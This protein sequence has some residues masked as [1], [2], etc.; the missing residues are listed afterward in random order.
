MAKKKSD[1]MQYLLILV[2]GIAIAG[3]LFYMIPYRYK[4][5][6]TETYACDHSMVD[7]PLMGFA[8]DAQNESQC[9]QARLVYINLTWAEW[10]PQKGKFNT[11]ALEENYHIAQYMA[12]NKHA[13]LRFVCDL[14]GQSQHMDIPKWLYDE[15][16]DGT[17]YTNEYGQGYSPNYENPEFLEAH[18]AAI[19]ALGAYCNK[20]QFVSFV[21]LGS[22]GHWGEWHAKGSQNQNLMPDS[23]VCF[24][25][26]E[27]YA[28]S[29][30]NVILL[31]RRNYDFAVENEMGFYQDMMGHEEDSKE[32]LGWMK[33]GD[34]QE[35]KGTS[36]VLT[37][38]DSFGKKVPVGGEL[39]SAIS[40]KDLMNDQFG[41][42]LSLVS[43]SKMTFLGPMVPDL[44]DEETEKARQSL[45]KEM[46]YRIYISKLETQYQFKENTLNL[47]L[48][49]KND[50]NAGFFFNW[51]V[52]VN[53]YD[54]DKQRIYW[55]TLD[56]DL[57]DL[58]DGL[59]KV[60]QA[61]IPYTDSIREEFYVGIC[62][63][64]FDGKD[65]LKLAMDMEENLG[66]IGNSQIIY[67]YTR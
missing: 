27:Q 17:Y 41:T 6:T 15:I 5:N 13:V 33:D 20:H 59:E 62:I 48:T 61:Q 56:L 25:Y 67:H 19:T 3:I 26:A 2:L 65:Q 44:T 50:G 14:P 21:E 22:L 52:T 23:Q 9:E 66:Y 10:E 38:T 34:E 28:D 63:T 47:N 12:E 11:K 30:Q 58:N 4:L 60:V 7:N 16:Q 55:Q 37:P 57:R 18:K 43:E 35:T 36:L 45:L 64:D 8:P 1:L 42:L 54:T 24:T 46:G 39:T 49:F 40:M 53:V 29:F 51:P 32:W 31:T